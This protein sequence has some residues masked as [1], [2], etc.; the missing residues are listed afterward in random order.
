[1]PVAHFHL[2]DPTPEQRREILLRASS[3]YA[4]LLEAPMDRVRIFVQSYPAEAVATKGEVVAEGG[5]P[6]PY[7]T[8]LTLAGRPAAQRSAITRAFTDLLAEV[9]EVDVALVRGQIIEVAPENWSIGGV[10]ASEVRAAEIA[11]RQSKS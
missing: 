7:F 11:A 9:L 8:A 10:P 3:L 6:A 5:S 2:T 1:M 4:Q